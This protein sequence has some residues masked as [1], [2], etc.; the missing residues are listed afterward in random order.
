MLIFLAEIKALL[1]FFMHVGCNNDMCLQCCYF[2][3]ITY[4]MVSQFYLY[5]VD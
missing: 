1:F 2:D 4:S 5:Y 3:I